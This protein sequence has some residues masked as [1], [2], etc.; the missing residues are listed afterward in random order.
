MADDF[1]DPFERMLE[2]L[3]PPDRVRA[4]DAGDDSAAEWNKIEDSGF[5]DALRAEE[6]GGVGLPFSQIVDLWMALGRHAVPLPVGEEMV[7]RAAGTDAERN[8]TGTAIL[9]AAQIAG[10]ADRLLEMSVAHANQ[11]VQF[12]KPVGRQQAVQQQLAV[13]AEE[14]IAARMAVELAC[15]GEGWPGAMPAAAA[16]ASASRIAPLIAS[17]AHAV[18]GAIGISAEFDLQLYT[19]RLYRWRAAGGSEGMWAREI[20]ERVLDTDHTA[21]TWVRRELFGDEEVVS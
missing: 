13:M 6:E 20:G 8:R 3:F 15:A 17:A 19:S 5:L 16:K 12:G 11:R 2:K 10:A 14:A 18:H 4:I 7:A 21:L 1:L 9:H